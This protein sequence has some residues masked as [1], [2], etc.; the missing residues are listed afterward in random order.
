M[1]IWQE[2]FLFSKGTNLRSKVRCYDSPY[3]EDANYHEAEFKNVLVP[4]STKKFIKL[5]LLLFFNSL[6]IAIF[7][8]SNLA[9]IRLFGVTG[10]EATAFEFCKMILINNDSWWK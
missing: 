10:A 7:V 1:V 2:L 3:Q 6:A 4:R 5:S 9:D 8:F